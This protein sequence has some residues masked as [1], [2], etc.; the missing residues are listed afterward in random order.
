MLANGIQESQSNESPIS[1]P[2]ST[3]T[4]T[5]SCQA[6]GSSL[7]LCTKE[8]GRDSPFEAVARIYARH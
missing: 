8:G 4:Q 6:E 1:S 5:S 7:E 2:S 3:L